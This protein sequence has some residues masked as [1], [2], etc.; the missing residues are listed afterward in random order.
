MKWNKEHH[1][2]S[3][4]RGRGYNNWRSADGRFFL[5]Q[6]T[7]GA[8][9]IISTTDNTVPFTGFQGKRTG[10]ALAN[11]IVEAKR[12]CEIVAKDMTQSTEAQS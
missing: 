10:T 4:P 1:P 12:M 2:N 5:R 6:N 8:R 7:C 11:T 9:W 3:N